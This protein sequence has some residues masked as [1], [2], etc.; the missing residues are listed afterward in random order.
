MHQAE[1][2]V[3]NSDGKQHHAYYSIQPVLPFIYISIFTREENHEENKTE[4][5]KITIP[6]LTSRLRGDEQNQMTKQATLE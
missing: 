3:R 2:D 5:H 1:F 6:P 4:E